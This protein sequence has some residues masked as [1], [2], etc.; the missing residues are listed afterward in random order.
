MLLSDMANSM[1]IYNHKVNDQFKEFVY[2]QSNDA[3][4]AGNAR[5]DKILTIEDLNIY[6]TKL[7]HDFIESIGGLP[8]SD[9]SLNAQITGTV[10]YD[11][12]RVEK[13][14]FE[15]RPRAFITANLYIPD[16]ITTPRGAILFVCGHVMEAK[17]DPMYQNVCMYLVNSGLVVMIQDPVGQGERLS[18]YEKSIKNV[19]VRWGTAEHEYSGCQS[20]LLGDAIARY[21]IHDAMRGIDYLCTRPEVDKTRIGITGNSGGGVQTSLMMI[22]DPRI[23]AAAPA[24][25]VM[26]RKTYMYMGEDQDAE[27]IWPGFT[28][29]GY[30]H[31]DILLSMAPR[32]ARVLAVQWDFF[33][34]EGTRQSVSRCKRFWDMYGKG[35]CFDMIEDASTHNYTD[36]LAKAVAEF[37]SLHLLGEKVASHHKNIEPINTKELVCTQT[38]QVR[39]EFEDTRFVF[40]ENCERMLEIEK[41][42]GALS[43]K[44]YK[45]RAL[46][47]LQNKV[48]KG[49]KYHDLNPRFHHTEL[50]EEFLSEMSFWWSQEGIFNHACMLR[51]YRYIDQ[52]IP[53]TIAVWN[54]GTRAMFSHKN[55]IRKICS[56]GRAMMILDVTADGLL[57]PNYLEN[58]KN[59]EESIGIHKLCDDLIWLNDSIVAVRT[60]DV[61]RALDMIDIWSGVKND[62]TEI[63]AYGN[64]GI[65]A[66]LATVLDMRVRNVCIENCIDSFAEI[67]RTR[68]YDFELGEIM[69]K[70]LPSVLKYF[71]LFKCLLMVNLT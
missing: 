19:T 58:S 71:D 1:R 37:F 3:F 60:Y 38:G 66:Q 18:Y 21:F 62:S 32:P 69:N 67:V 2:N 15:S 36:V 27:Q 46:H 43:E 70:V 28:A 68:H 54:G 49:R 39:S 47:W 55:V 14:I 30:D 45:D 64:H 48:F 53:V 41:S 33:P 9:T 7:R 23:Y 42:R 17:L 11:G 29:L 44:E 25:F 63:Y 16:N 56:K 24:T 65:Y 40:E 20:L 52:K 6:R 59:S 34:I 13:I 31:E 35:D 8:S 5:R 61:I 10:E 22:C 12:F 26:N 4:D 50:V 51:D 57:R